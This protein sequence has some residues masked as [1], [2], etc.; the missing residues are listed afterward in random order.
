[1]EHKIKMTP[2]V[3]L[4]CAFFWFMAIGL[5]VAGLYTIIILI[6]KMIKESPVL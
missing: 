5:T 3:I 6:M 4:N 2:K 1:M